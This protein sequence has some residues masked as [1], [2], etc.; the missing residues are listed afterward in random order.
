MTETARAHASVPAWDLPTRA[1][2]WTLL[3]LIVW[4]WV[5][6]SF[7]E[8]LGDTTLVYHRANG[9]AI[10]TL[11]IWRILWGFA[12]SST[13]R[14]AGFV[15]GPVTVAS[16]AS[17][18]LRG[19]AAR[20]LGHNPMGGLMVLAL[21]ATVATIGSLGLFAV[22]DNDL[23]GG[24]LY[25]L[26]GESQNVRLTRLHDQ[27]F[28]NALLPLVMLHI[29]VNSLYTLVKKDPLIQAMVTGRKPAME[30]ADAPRAGLASVGRAL[31][32]LAIAAT[33]V[34]GG[35]LALGGS[36]RL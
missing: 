2:H 29:A 23:V 7:A 1:F 15:Q 17:A 12:G 34:L 24:P 32:V 3:A 35:I 28:Y 27:V 25:R 13:S 26:V 30:Y 20:Y 31:I 36:L 10:L 33:I 5:S 9:L 19:R 8:A 11:I 21:L 14:F 16:Y 18:L 4:A 22:D 6:V